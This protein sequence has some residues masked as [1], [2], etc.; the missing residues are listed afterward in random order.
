MVNGSPSVWAKAQ[1][2]CL[3]HMHSTVPSDRSYL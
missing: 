1:S 3:G 2:R